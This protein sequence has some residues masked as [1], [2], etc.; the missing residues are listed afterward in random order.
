MD[1]HNYLLY[2]NSLLQ[3]K[4]EPAMSVLNQFTLTNATPRKDNSPV[5]R[6]RRRLSD[7]ISVQIDLAKAEISGEALNRT[8]Q[9][10][11]TDPTTGAN[12]LKT[13]PVRV[14]RWWWKDDAGK[15]FL[16]LKY[17]AK[18]LEIAP[19]KSAIEIAVAE[20]LP[21]KLEL[22]LE[23]VRGGELDQC[24]GV[25]AFARPLPAK[26]SSAAANKKSGSKSK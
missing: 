5:G 18:A 11:R 2:Y 14:R 7:A 4:G 3:A 26:A 13:V 6:F 23:A 17:G 9:R 25:A 8:R 19:G 16:T 20:E 15:T 12:H 10:W 22:L 24:A 1:L 21:A